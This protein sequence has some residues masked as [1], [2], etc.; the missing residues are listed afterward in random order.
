M[1]RTTSLTFNTA[2][3][4][5]LVSSLYWASACSDAQ[6][7]APRA[8]AEAVQTSS[9]ETSE[10][11]PTPEPISELTVETSAGSAP[12]DTFVDEQ[13][14]L[15]NTLTPTATTRGSTPGLIGL[16]DAA[17]LSAET[18]DL[19]AAAFAALPL[20]KRDKPAIAGAGATGIHLDE[21]E[22]GKGWESSRCQDTGTR[23]V[24]GTDERVNLC[25]RVVHPREAETVTVE[26]AFNGKVRQQ[27]EV[28][29]RPTHSYLTRA[30]L[31]I[32]PGRAGHWTA[33][34]K[35]QDGTI[36]GEREFDIAGE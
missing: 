10:R 1:R 6:E 11:A 9:T 7:P 4:A 33:T 24:A 23:F 29:V 21:L 5:L 30:W 27:I 25:F 31:P 32:R 17:M 8:A 14:V 28:S 12:A 36:L 35:S 26:W 15:A 3:T 20:S 22:L 2:L 18:P 19:N 34:V 16:R 13:P